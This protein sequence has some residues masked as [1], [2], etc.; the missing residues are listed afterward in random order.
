M[1]SMPRKMNGTHRFLDIGVLCIC[2]LV[3]YSFVDVSTTTDT[4]ALW[5]YDN[6][7]GYV[8]FGQVRA[9]KSTRRG[10]CLPGMQQ[11]IRCFDLFPSQC[12]DVGI[13]HGVS[14]EHLYRLHMLC[15]RSNVS[16]WYI[17]E[18]T[19]THRAF[20]IGEALIERSKSQMRG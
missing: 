6:L 18:S 14:C 1:Q 4:E 19:R 11:C 16:H 2:F 13:R 17:H 3:P 7:A 5:I 15:K 10:C 9:D 20:R 12:A 8:L